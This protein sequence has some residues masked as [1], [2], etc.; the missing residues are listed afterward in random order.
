MRRQIGGRIF[1]CLLLAGLGRAQQ[2]QLGADFSH[3]ATDFSQ[4]CGAFS[5]KTLAGCGETL[6]TDHPLHIAVGSLPPGNGF[7]VGP[8]FVAH[9][10]P[11]ERWRLS[12]DLDAVASSN[13]SWRAGGYM[14]AVYIPK[15]K[16]VVTTGGTGS[17]PSN[18]KVTEYPI[19]HA[20]AQSISL[21]TLAFFGEGPDTRDTARSYYGM[22]Q[23]I[24]GANVV[25]PVTW[26]V[27]SALKPS[28][29]GE[30][31]SRSVDIRASTGQGSPSIEQLYTP[32]TAPGLVNQPG[33]AQFGEGIRFR[34]SFAGDYIRLNYLVNYQ[35]YIAPGTSGYSF[36]RFTTDLQHQFPIYSKTRTLLPLDH[37]GPD[38]CSEDPTDT[39]HKCPP[40]ITNNLEG[41]FGIRF[42]LSESIIPAGN[43]EPFYFQPTLGG[44]DINGNPMLSSYQDYRYRA[45]NLM[46]IHGSFE[47]SIYKW[48]LGIA[49]M[50]DEGKVADRRSDIDFSHMVHSYSA[51]LTLRAGGFPM[52]YLLF[53]WGG[54]EGTHTTG[55][56]NTSLLGGASRPG[57][58]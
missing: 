17:K 6:F 56:M 16:I 7:G 49:L 57:L 53:S 29:L 44:S 37:N 31:N 32:V 18:L 42:L 33:Y 13:L 43:I 34:P 4:S 19:F 14:T 20:Y 9:L 26:G 46:L 8:A 5:L 2:S 55:S 35:E 10:T 38:D 11:N 47:H 12:W 39:M 3:E 23:T 1:A 52:V 48:P 36:H 50:I 51:G 30:A 24:A 58:F 27:L 40:M 54:H 25:W 22:Q 21:N 15:R 41:S 28:L 45:P